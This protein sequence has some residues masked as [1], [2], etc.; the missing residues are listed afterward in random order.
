MGGIFAV[1]AH[2]AE[3]AGVQIDGSCKDVARLCFMSLGSR[4]LLKP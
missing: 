4:R 3:L 2:V 1:R